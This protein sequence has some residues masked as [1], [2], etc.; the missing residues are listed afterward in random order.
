MREWLSSGL[1]TRGC[2]FESGQCLVI[3]RLIKGSKLANEDMDGLFFGGGAIEHVI[4]GGEIYMRSDQIAQLIGQTGVK[5]ALSAIQQNDPAS[6]A[7]GHMM[8]IVSEKIYEL[9]SELLKR[10]LEAAL[11]DL[12][13]WRPADFDD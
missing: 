12:S 8:M 9:R 4:D 7:T 5:M 1:Q 10:E 11:P 6:A 3:V 13:E 2:R